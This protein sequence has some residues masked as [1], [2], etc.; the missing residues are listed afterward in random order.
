MEGF[1]AVFARVGRGA[2]AVPLRVF[3]AHEPLFWR[4]AA[5]GDGGETTVPDPAP[6]APLTSS[7]LVS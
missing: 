6:A 5:A 2:D 7:R 3:L 4:A 1:A